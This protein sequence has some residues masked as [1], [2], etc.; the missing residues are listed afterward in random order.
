MLRRKAIVRN[1]L[2]S[3]VTKLMKMNLLTI[4]TCYR[5][6]PEVLHLSLERL[7]KESD[8]TLIEILNTIWLS[9]PSTITTLSYFRNSVLARLSNREFSRTQ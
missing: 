4:E 8:E 6:P 3:H 1:A 5:T 7:Q 2:V 9:K